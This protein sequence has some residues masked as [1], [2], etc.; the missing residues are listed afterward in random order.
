MKNRERFRT[1]VAI[2]VIA[3][4]VLLAAGALGTVMLG[5]GS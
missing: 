5:G 4:M 1:I 2:T 3:A